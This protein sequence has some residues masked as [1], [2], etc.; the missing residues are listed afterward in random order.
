MTVK[1]N[2]KP[3]KTKSMPSSYIS[4]DREWAD[5]DRID[6]E[7]PMKVT[8]EELNHLPSYVSILRGPIVMGARLDTDAPLT[9]LIAD[10]HRWAH[11]AHGPLVS[12][13]DTPLL[14]GKRSEILKKAQRHET[15]KRRESEIFG[16]RAV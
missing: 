14:I 1:V 2:G 11:I 4:I 16:A 8:I 3:I 9:G 12:V 15:S 13:F 6:I 10:D 7:M 5:N